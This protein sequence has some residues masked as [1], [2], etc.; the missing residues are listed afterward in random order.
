MDVTSFLWIQL[1]HWQY[2]ESMEHQNTGIKIS[3]IKRYRNYYLTYKS[4]KRH[5][6]EANLRVLVV[7]DVFLLKVNVEVGQLVAQ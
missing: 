3:D 2:F 6:V 5:K 7:S 1:D 4:L